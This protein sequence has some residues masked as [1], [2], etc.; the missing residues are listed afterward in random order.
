MSIRAITVLTVLAVSMWFGP[1]PASAQTNTRV[2]QTVA[3]G[4]SLTQ[5]AN[6]TDTFKTQQAETPAEDA[7]PE[8]RIALV[9]GNSAYQSVSALANPTNDGKAISQ[10]L[11]TAG[12]DVIQAVDLTRQQMT[13][14]LESFSKMI[15]DRGPNTVA[16][17]YYA[18]HGLQVDG[19]N[20]LVP[21]DAK[22]EKEDDVAE[23]TVR[24]VDVMKTLEAVPSR[25]RI[26]ILD[27]CRNN[28]FSTIGDAAG[29]GLAIVDAPTG[30]IVAYSTAP[31]SEALDGRGTHSPYAAALMRVSKE[32]GLSIELL[33]KRVRLLVND[34]TDGK[35]VPWESSSLTSDFEFFAV[36][37]AVGKIL[38]PPP[39]VTRVAELATRPAPEAY[40]IAIEEDSVEY[41][42]EFVRLYPTH[43]LCDRVRTLLSR[44]LQT[45]AWHQAVKSNTS[46]DYANFLGRFG[47][48][49]FAK[50][51]RR[52]QFKP[53]SFPVQRVVSK[54]EFNNRQFFRNGN[55]N[56]GGNFNNRNGGLQKVGFP[57]N[58]NGG[59]KI[60]NND[61]RNNGNVKINLPGNNGRPDVKVAIPNTKIGGLRNGNTG[62]AGNLQNG[63]RITLQN[64]RFD[65]RRVLNERLVNNKIN[66]Q[67]D[68]QVNRIQ[69]QPRFQVQPR[70]QVQ[71]RVQSRVQFQQRAQFSAARNNGGGFGNKSFRRR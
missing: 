9:I 3:A 66:T 12:F 64:N 39:K 30:S 19:E 46:A 7:G 42:E 33:F 13:D 68:R 54:L 43:P 34:V 45:V 61:R 2:I 44:R 23:Q 4:N 27:A 37:D 21:V 65:N 11:T 67:I 10:F 59:I 51:A 22:I 71:Q 57:G 60:G 53:R 56:N 32:R 52:L 25:V 38:P 35:Q 48:S 8:K 36:G 49:D 5:V 6:L 31:G 50:A 40:T 18:G 63:G 1:S 69:V 14:V 26:V 20:F 41:Y 47:R 62:I 58:N 70:A 28:P 17:V 15:S 16:L 24:L 29:K 55:F